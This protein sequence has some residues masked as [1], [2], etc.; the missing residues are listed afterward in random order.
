MASALV[1]EDERIVKN[2]LSLVLRRSNHVV[3]QAST[4]AE[5]QQVLKEDSI[6][7]LIADVRLP[8]GE[9]GTAFALHTKQCNPGIKIVLLSGLPICH[10]RH[11][12]AENLANLPAG[13][14]VVL[15]KPVAT[16]DIIQAVD[17]LLPKR[18]RS[19]SAAS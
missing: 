8:G 12:D 16:A 19:A 15:G 5:A 4:V 14:V 18:P 10:W 11:E 9:S 2:F 1:L 3:R 7:V 17:S 13:S 6:E